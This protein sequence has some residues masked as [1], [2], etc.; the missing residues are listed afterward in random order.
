MCQHI[1][2]FL[3][4]IILILGIKEVWFI[5]GAWELVPDGT[6][7]KDRLESACPDLLF[8]KND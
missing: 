8:L 3:S 1:T 7:R 2:I 6:V 4:S 5:G